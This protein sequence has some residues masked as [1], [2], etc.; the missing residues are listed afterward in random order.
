MDDKKGKVEIMKNVLLFDIDGTLVNSTGDSE[1]VHHEVMRARGCTRFPTARESSGLTDWGLLASINSLNSN[2]VSENELQVCFAELD[3]AY[4]RKLQDVKLSNCIGVSHSNLSLLSQYFDL[5]ILTGNTYRRAFNKIEKIGI[6]AFFRKE[7]I[8]TAKAR[9][10]RDELAARVRNRFLSTMHKAIVVGDTPKDI[11]AAKNAG[12]TSIGIATGK[13]SVDE[14]IK[15]SPD[16]VI[17]NLDAGITQI[18]EFA[19]SQK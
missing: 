3:T 12:L 6:N 10:S 5:G 11:T 18:L 15:L 17:S 8:F 16:L 2:K 9:E 19:I 1:P 13:F 14:L 7:L 4:L